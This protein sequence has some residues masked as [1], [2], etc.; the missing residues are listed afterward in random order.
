MYCSHCGMGNEESA[1]YC[2]S[3]G[4]PLKNNE[5]VLPMKSRRKLLAPIIFMLLII[6]SGAMAIF[7]LLNKPIK[8]SDTRL[9]VDDKLGTVQTY[10]T[11]EGGV[12]ITD[13]GTDT[14][15]FHS[16]GSRF[17]VDGIL[18]AS[19]T[20]MDGTEAAFVSDNTLYYTNGEEPQ[21]IAA[22]IYSFA[23]ALSGNAVTYTTQME[24]DQGDLYIYS[25]GSSD[26]IASNAF[27]NYCCISPDGKTVTYATD[28]G[29]NEEP[30]NFIWSN[31]QS[32]QFG[33]GLLP[34][35]ITDGAQ[36]VYYYRNGAFCVREGFDAGTETE[37]GDSVR[38]IAFSSDCAQVVYHNNGDAYISISG[39][40]GKKLSGNIDSFILPGDTQ[41]AVQY[42]SW[43]Q[44]MFIYG[45]NG[46]ANTF[47]SSGDQV[48][49]INEAFESSVIVESA[50]EVE[51]ASDGRTIAYLD[52]D[53]IYRIDGLV[54]GAT[55]EVWMDD[56]TEIVAVFDDNSCYFFNSNSEL[57]YQN[58]NSIMR[59]VEDDA[60]Y[61]DYFALYQFNKVL[62]ISKGNLTISS[63]G[64]KLE[65]T[66]E[67][68]GNITSI[69]RIGTMV[70]IKIDGSQ[71]ISIDGN[72]FIYF[73]EV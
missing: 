38:S 20:S 56:A 53:A 49:R 58:D 6:V 5:I 68:N 28:G 22:D 13:N 37:L 70:I 29:D 26:H 55:A 24:G 39:E 42:D 16:N 17:T 9:V 59:V 18:N 73:A 63:N 60:L 1:K 23:L 45:V 54:D 36:Y 72:S 32:S 50:E 47:Y 66:V 30:T 57:C 3:C 8:A 2:K 43:Q 25:N 21:V 33:I 61:R 35:M 10:A 19:Q 40:E 64:E 44:P 41:T 48:L 34:V 51:L 15:V 27:P 69:N 65:S 14:L 4:R 7:Y 46:F 12:Y 31:G 62:Y 11:Y 71:Y 67:D 52:Y